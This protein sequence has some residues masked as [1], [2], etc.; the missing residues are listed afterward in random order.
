MK[1]RKL[2]SRKVY[3]RIHSADLKGEGRHKDEHQE[4]T[5]A[6]RVIGGAYYRRD[7]CRARGRGEDEKLCSKLPMVRMQKVRSVQRKPKGRCQVH[8]ARGRGSEER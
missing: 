8:A 5:K 1:V 7:K 6:G 4:G 3:Y 2:E